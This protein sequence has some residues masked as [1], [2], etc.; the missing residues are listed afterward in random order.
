MKNDRFQVFNA[1]QP[2]EYREWVGRWNAWPGREAMAHPDYARLFAG[3]KDSVCCAVMDFPDGCVLLPIVLRPLAAEP[4]AG[5]MAGSYDIVS[6]YGYGGPYCIGQVGP[7]EFWSEFERWARGIGA[8]D[9][10]FRLSLQDCCKEGISG[11]T[12]LVNHNIVCDL[13]RSIDEIW[14]Q[15]NHKVR[16][17][18]KRARFNR[19]R[20]EVD[21]QGGR[22][23]EFLA[24]YYSTMD[25]RHAPSSYYFDR[26][27]FLRL[28]RSLP[29]SFAFF[30]V[31]QE[32]TVVS[33]EL[34][35]VSADTLYSFLGGTMEQAF[36]LRPNELLKHTVIEWGIEQQKR[37]FV[38]GGGFDGDDGIYAYKKSFA[39]E[40]EVAFYVNSFILEP[41]QYAACIEKRRLHEAGAGREWEPRDGYFPEYRG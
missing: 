30:H 34:V 40:G 41:D 39:P 33:T 19:L 31:L 2:E 16:K 35:L 10:F 20:V 27:F 3:E 24:V 36:E 13:T 7:T 17:N 15:Y 32:Q 4:W 28:I 11:E 26:D 8:I 38:L 23:D 1:A 22:L 21:L 18:V 14:R 37:A 5:E 12:R 6:P 29:G 9:W 25:R